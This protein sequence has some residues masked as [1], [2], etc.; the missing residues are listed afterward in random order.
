M[1]DMERRRFETRVHD[2]GAAHAASFPAA[3]RGAELLAIINQVVVEFAMHATAQSSGFTTKAQ[4]AAGRATWRAALREDLEA[5]N[6]TARAMSFNTPG[7]DEC[8]RL[9]RNNRN[10]TRCS[11]RRATFMP[12][13]FRSKPS[14]S[15]TICP[16]IFSTLYSRT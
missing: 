10:V 4:A 2:F 11:R 7:L 1:R 5:I 12:P 3:S 15:V 14:S 6:R 9:P 16:P 8:F 13:P